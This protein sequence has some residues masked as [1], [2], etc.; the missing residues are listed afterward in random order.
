[1]SADYITRLAGEIVV[2]ADAVGSGETDR[3]STTLDQITEMRRL[4]AAVEEEVSQKGIAPASPL[5]PLNTDA[6]S[7]YVYAR[8][9][10]FKMHRE[11]GHCILIFDDFLIDTPVKQFSD[12]VNGYTQ[13]LEWMRDYS[14][15]R[16]IAIRNVRIKERDIKELAFVTEGAI[17]YVLHEAGEGTIFPRDTGYRELYMLLAKRQQG[18]KTLQELELFLKTHIYHLDMELV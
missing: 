16:E 13:A 10:G 15:D 7:L 9:H 8:A 3:A 6:K 2:N 17:H 4:L 5:D 1:M 12:D 18:P 14:G 11:P